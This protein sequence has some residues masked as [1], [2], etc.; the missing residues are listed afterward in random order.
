MIFSSKER[1]KSHVEKFFWRIVFCFL[2][3]FP[4]TLNGN[5]WRLWKLAWYHPGHFSRRFPIAKRNRIS[6][7]SYLRERG[8]IQFECSVKRRVQT[9]IREMLV[10]RPRCASESFCPFCT[11][12]SYLPFIARYPSTAQH[13]PT[14]YI[15]RPAPVSKYGVVYSRVVRGRKRRAPRLV[16][17]REGLGCALLFH[18]NDTT[19]TLRLYASPDR[20]TIKLWAHNCDS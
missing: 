18:H 8:K 16:R 3:I 5:I 1:K 7:E 12:S 10:R 11:P 6:V 15:K 17:L 2:I 19:L 4:V 13:M 20:K 14:K 9:P